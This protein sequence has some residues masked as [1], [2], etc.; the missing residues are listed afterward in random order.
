MVTLLADHD[1]VIGTDVFKGIN[2]SEWLDSSGK[3]TGTVIAQYINVDV[4]IPYA[5]KIRG[6]AQTSGSVDSQT[7]LTGLMHDY[8]AF[9]Y[10][11]T[12]FTIETGGEANAG[13]LE[14]VDGNFNKGTLDV[15]VDGRAMRATVS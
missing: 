14:I 9:G 5:T 12:N 2:M 6:K 4:P 11:S 7:E 1:P 15:F 13:G 3:N 10:D 8:V